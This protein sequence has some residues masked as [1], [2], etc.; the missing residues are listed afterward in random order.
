MYAKLP[1]SRPRQE[2]LRRH[3]WHR[4][5]G[6]WRW[7]RW[8]RCGAGVE[9]GPGRKMEKHVEKS[10][11][12]FI[13]LYSHSSPFISIHLHS[14][15]NSLT[16]LST[17]WRHCCSSSCSLGPLACGAPKPKLGCQSPPG[18]HH[19][20]FYLTLAHNRRKVPSIPNN[21]CPSQNKS[22]GSQL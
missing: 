17:I 15:E 3:R 19:L 9:S 22:I 20:I 4:P 7:G 11:I 14:P 13:H 10:N 21:E 5:W 18:Q 1:L 6:R 16:P 12:G 2:A 8:G